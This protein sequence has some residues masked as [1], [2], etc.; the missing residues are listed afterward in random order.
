MNPVDKQAIKTALITGAGRRIG[1]SITKALHEAGFTT[2]IHC[3]TSLL[4]AQQLAEQ[5]NSTRPDSA[6]VLQQDLCAAHAATRLIDAC[7]R[8]TGRIDV[9]INNASVFISNMFDDFDE[10]TWSKLFH[11]N[12]KVPFSLSITARDALMKT[13]GSII[14]ISDIHG[15][16]PLRNYTLYCQTKAA[17]DMQ[18]K[19]LAKEFAPDIRVNAIAPGA[20][21]WPEKD[22][23]LNARQRQKIIADTPLKK[24]GHPCYVAQAV[25]ALLNNHFISGQIVNVDGGRSIG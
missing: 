14:N 6:F 22:N 11:T 12:V 10:S 18:T 1:A 19:S 16:K 3:H 5:L 21:L 25:L 17:L 8:I 4:P 2:I 13:G 23:R 9:L 7:I 24:H 15:Q 20:I